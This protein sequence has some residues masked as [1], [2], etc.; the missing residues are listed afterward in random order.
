MIK[1]LIATLI[2]FGYGCSSENHSPCRLQATYDGTFASSFNFREDNSFEWTNGLVSSN[3]GFYTCKDNIITLD[4]IGFDKVIKSKKLLITTVHPISGS[5]G[6][7]LV[8]VDEKNN[9]IDSMYIFTIYID[10]RS[11]FK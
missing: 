5:R 4:K 3:E 1:F 8:Q 2:L 7:Y 10:N 6:K 11:S 9:L